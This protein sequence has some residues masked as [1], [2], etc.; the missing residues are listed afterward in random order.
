MYANYVR[1]SRYVYQKTAFI[2]LYK[3]LVKEL[4]DSIQKRAQSGIFANKTY[5]EINFNVDL[6]AYLVVETAEKIKIIRIND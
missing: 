5:R 4:H 3:R 2:E 1:K 6:P